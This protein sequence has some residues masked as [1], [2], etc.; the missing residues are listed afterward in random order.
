MSFYRQ[1]LGLI[2]KNYYY[3]CYCC[4]YCYCYY[5]CYCCFYDD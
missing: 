4:C 1:Y 3:F 5:Y 2:A